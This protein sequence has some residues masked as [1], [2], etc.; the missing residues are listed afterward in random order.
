MPDV[1]RKRRLIA[2]AITFIAVALLAACANDDAPADVSVLDATD[3]VRQVLL[4]DSWI[5]SGTYRLLAARKA[6]NVDEGYWVYAAR[7]DAPGLSSTVLFWRAE[8]EALGDGLIFGNAVTREFS[9]WGSAAT[10]N[11]PAA[12]WVRE[13]ERSSYGRA[14]VEAVSR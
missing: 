14:V 12:D 11:S 6:F 5:G 1:G 3:E 9:V 8:G 13:A 2:A 7:I 10:A 4:G